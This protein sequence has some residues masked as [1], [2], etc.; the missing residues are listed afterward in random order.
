MPNP[1][2]LLLPS[3]PLVEYLIYL[4]CNS[5]INTLYIVP[6]TGLYDSAC[7]SQSAA[8]TGWYGGNF[9][10]WYND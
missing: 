4:K 10:E 2:P 5:N 9:K 8:I 1:D 6:K 3:H 7:K